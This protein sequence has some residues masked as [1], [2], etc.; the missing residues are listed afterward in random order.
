MITTA[1]VTFGKFILSTLLLLA[2]YSGVLR[3]KASYTMQRLYLILIPFASIMMSGLTF[4]VYKPEARIIEME[5]PEVM[6]YYEDHRTTGYAIIADEGGSLESL[7]VSLVDDLFSA[8][9]NVA[10]E[11]G[12]IGLVV[13]ALFAVSA[14]LLMIAAYYMIKMCILRRRLNAEMTDD[15]YRLICSG[16]IKVPFSFADTIFLP[17][18]MESGKADYIL[19]HE[20]A[21]IA[22]KHYVDVWIIEFMTRLLWFNPLMWVVRRQLR[23]VHEY[24]ADRC[25]VDA[26]VDM[27]RYQT[28]LLEEVA[29]DSMVI[30]NGFY[31][32]FIRSRF[33]EM[34]KSAI[35][36]MGIKGKTGTVLWIIA[37]FCAF[38]FTVGEAETIVRYKDASGRKV[39]ML[40]PKSTEADDRVE[41]ETDSMK[42]IIPAN[43]LNDTITIDKVRY[44]ISDTY[45]TVIGVADPEQQVVS[46]PQAITVG[47][48]KL[49]VK[50]I[51]ANAFATCS[52]LEKV[53]LPETI[54]SIHDFAFL[55]CL[56]LKSVNIPSSAKYVASSAFYLCTGFPE[57]DGII[58]A[59]KFLVKIADQ[60]R[61]SYKIRNGTRWIGSNAFS[62]N[63]HFSIVELP[64]SIRVI[65]AFAFSN[66]TGLKSIVIPESVEIIEDFAFSSC[67]SLDNID[68]RGNNVK[69]GKYIFRGT[70]LEDMATSSQTNSLK[71]RQQL[72]ELAKDV[73]QFF[74]PVY[75]EG[76]IDVAIGD[77]LYVF[78]APYTAHVKVKKDIGRK[79][80][81]V[82]LKNTDKEICS[83]VAIWADNHEPAFVYFSHHIGFNFHFISFND[84][85]QRGID[86]KVRITKY[87]KIMDIV[88]FSDNN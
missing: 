33:I 60:E 35:G 52:S 40:T 19:M 24:E 51:G 80:F 16:S 38:T 25:V 10:E 20:K 57:K 2:F 50:S 15:G 58:Y 83:D 71:S 42:G 43:V 85:K 67:S 1:L 74:A 39:E 22:H 54:D 23:N 7:D 47:K 87:E 26:G 48:N 17:A 12:I 68:I 5:K 64:N 72:A 29:E 82:H 37:L 79:Y 44:S 36:C 27:F 14:V 4:E 31:H 49:A 45:A 41:E 88:T 81:Y 73:T 78:D 63:P 13:C 32:S 75:L 70:P 30:A 28:I 86:E 8:I 56:K 59:D 84:F 9:Q 46:I 69:V 62:Q 11:L 21:H 3:S 53:N 55:K 34:K 61:K 76:N 66:C 65:G 6:Q 77:T 18:D